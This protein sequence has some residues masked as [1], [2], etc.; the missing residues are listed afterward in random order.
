MQEGTVSL[1]A[2]PDGSHPVRGEEPAPKSIAWARE[3]F[4][5]TCDPAVIRCYETDEGEIGN[6]A[7][8]A[9]IEG[10]I[11]RLTLKLR[12]VDSAAPMPPAA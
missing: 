6:R 3:R 10:T 11:A 8:L 7:Q 4:P 9:F 1:I 12:R 5:S 2:K